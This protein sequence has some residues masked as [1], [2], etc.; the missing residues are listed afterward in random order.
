[1]SDDSAAFVDTNVLVYSLDPEPSLKQV[2][3]ADLVDQLMAEDRI[4]VSTQ[5]LQELFATLTQKTQ[6]R[7]TVTEALEYLDRLVRWPL[8]AIDYPLIRSAGLLTEKVSISFW[9]ALIVA[10][11]ARS[12]ADTLYT[13]DLSHGEQ[14][15]G[16]RIVNPFQE[17]A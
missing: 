17:A 11:A 16:V 12:G 9:D 2:R 6:P 10:A 1:M 7:W 4:R 5:V 14:I 13:E 3:A 15:L 8:C